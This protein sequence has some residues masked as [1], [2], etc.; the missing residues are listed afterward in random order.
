[1]KQVVTRVTRAWKLDANV[2]EEIEHDHGAGP[3]AFAVVLCASACAGIGNMIAARVLGRGDVGW[4]SLLVLA[5]AFVVCWLSWSFLTMLVGTLLFGG[6]AD[7]GEMQ[8]ALGLAAAPGILML[9]PGLGAIVGVPL[10]AAAMIL[11]VRQAL[12]FTT[13]KALATVGIAGGV[14][15]LLVAPAFALALRG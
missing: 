5:T 15:L 4:T 8:R 1:M 7:M 9:V 11:A 2:F 10:S 12:D 6:V 14:T 13:A 3:Q